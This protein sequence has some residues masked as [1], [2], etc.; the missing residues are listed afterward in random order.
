MTYPNCGIALR[1]MKVDQAGVIDVMTVRVA[2]K[3]H[4]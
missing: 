3:N 1:L 4:N 2:Y